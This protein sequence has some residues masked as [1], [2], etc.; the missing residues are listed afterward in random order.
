[1]KT[2]TKEFIRYTNLVFERVVPHLG[3]NNL[4]TVLNENV[5]FPYLRLEGYALQDEDEKFYHFPPVRVGTKL[6][7]KNDSLTVSRPLTIENYSHPFIKN[8]GQFKNIGMVDIEEVDKLR[9]SDTM[10]QVL[11]VL[12]MGKRRLQ[13]DYGKIRCFHKLRR[14]ENL[15]ITKEDIEKLG[16]KVTNV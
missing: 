9:D 11:A 12:D 8:P 6:N 4:M 10:E 13:N 3:E 2:S 16:L 15:L 7:L 5:V 14:F 1:M